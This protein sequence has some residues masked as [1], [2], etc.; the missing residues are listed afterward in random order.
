MNGAFHPH[1][2]PPPPPN[3]NPEVAVKVGCLLQCLLVTVCLIKKNYLGSLGRHDVLG[4]N[5]GSMQAIDPLAVPSTFPSTLDAARLQ[6]APHLYHSV[7]HLDG[8]IDRVRLCPCLCRL[9]T[10][11]QQWALPRYKHHSVCGMFTPCLQKAIYTIIATS[12]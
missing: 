5:L 3:A 2:N 12:C 1:G 10:G 8:F 4:D 7:G 9:E 11:P 6:R